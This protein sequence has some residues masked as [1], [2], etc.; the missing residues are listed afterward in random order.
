MNKN[1]L[2][3]TT[4]KDVGVDFLINELRQFSSINVFR[5]NIEDYPSK[6]EIVTNVDNNG[7]VENLINFPHQGVLKSSE[8]FSAFYRRESESIFLEDIKSKENKTFAKIEILGHLDTIWDTMNCF[9][10]NHPRYS[11]SLM[12][13]VA[14]IH[15]AGKIGFN[16]PETVITTDYN[17]LKK[18]YNKHNGNIIAKQLGNARGAQDWIEGRLY[19][20]KI[21]EKHLKLFENSLKTPVMFQE[22]IIKDTEL[23]ITIVNKDIFSIK[24]DSQSKENTKIDWRRGPVGKMKHSVFDIPESVKL[25]LLDLHK[26][27]GLVYSGTDMIINPQGE[28]ILLELNP[29]G[30]YMWTEILSGA[31]ITKSIANLLIEGK[32]YYDRG[33][34]NPSVSGVS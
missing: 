31:P 23:R 30:E 25:K 1:I 6:I 16:V 4:S 28:Y 2:I 32:S 11:T 20:Q 9:W 29:N 22:L 27:L 33:G 3:I 14:Q 26:T 15:Y 13:K 5:F 19:T 12:T 34:K 18:F 7:K 8:V 17:I 21:E 24:I 10:V